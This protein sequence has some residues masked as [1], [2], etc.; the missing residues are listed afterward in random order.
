MFRLIPAGGGGHGQRS[1]QIPSCHRHMV[2]ATILSSLLCLAALQHKPGVVVGGGGVCW[3]RQKNVE[4]CE[5]RS[6][7]A[8]RQKVAHKKK[9]EFVGSN[10]S[11]EKGKKWKQQGGTGYGG[12]TR[13]RWR[14]TL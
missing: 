2:I 12:H 14:T 8:R 6:E 7:I 11:I 5:K 9:M 10:M 3:P 1:S 13:K 4:K